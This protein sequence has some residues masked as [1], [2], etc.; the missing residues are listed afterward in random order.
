MKI[1]KEQLAQIIKEELTSVVAED[2]GAFLRGAAGAGQDTI[3]VDKIKISSDGSFKAKVSS[4][5]LE[6]RITVAG[7]LDQ[8]STA[9]LQ[10]AGA[11]EKAKTTPIQKELNDKLDEMISA[12]D[13]AEVPPSL[14]TLKGLFNAG[15]HAEAMGEIQNH[16]E[17]L[18]KYH[19]RK[20]TRLQHKITTGFNTINTLLRKMS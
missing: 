1:T 9:L 11:L 5:Q 17:K 12:Y 3:S 10:Q 6:K 18:L 13:G 15:E 8:N 16:W 19:Q 20:G 14:S 4:A 2:Q 7:Q